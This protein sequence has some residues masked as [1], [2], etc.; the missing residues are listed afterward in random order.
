M[1]IVSSNCASLSNYEVFE[2]LQ[3]VKDCR[4]KHKGQL[5]TITYETLRYLENTPCKEQTAQSIKECI[6]ELAPFKLHKTELLMIINN[7][8]ITPLEIQFI[9]E[10]SEE[11]LTE[12]QVQEILAIIAKH[13]PHV[14]KTPPD[15]DE[16]S[17]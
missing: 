14:I 7:P 3:K 2:H 15:E 11:R 10:E 5:A 16:Q 4:P 17:E 1:E 8:P 6:R 9:V 12:D 13:F